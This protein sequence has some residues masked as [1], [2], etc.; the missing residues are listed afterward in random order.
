MRFAEIAVNAAAPIRQTFTYAIPD[1]VHVEPGQAVY[2][3]FGA[4][5][6]QGIVVSLTETSEFEQTREIT[7]VIDPRPLLSLEHIALARWLSEYYIAPLFDCISLMLPP[8][9]RRKPLIMLRPLASLDEVPT[10]RLTDLQANVLRRAI[11]LGEID[12]DD[13]K[14]EVKLPRVAGRDRGADQARLPPALLPAR[15]AA[16]CAE[17][18]TPASARHARRG[19]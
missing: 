9:F 4:R 11:E 8:G 12:M 2:V 1:D 3:P 6:L 10:L 19:G 7:D 15:P 5:T 18:R 16:D 14:R 17:G 13:L